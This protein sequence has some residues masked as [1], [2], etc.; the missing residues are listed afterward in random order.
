[1]HNCE[2]ESSAL[3]GQVKCEDDSCY[4]K[5]ITTVASFRS[6]DSDKDRDMLKYLKADQFAEVVIEGK[7][8]RTHED[9]VFN[10]KLSLAGRT[11]PLKPMKLQ[12]EKDWS[13]VRIR[14]DFDWSIFDF[15]IEAPK[16]LGMPIQ[17]VVRMFIDITFER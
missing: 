3:S 1:M 5:L 11:L 7:A 16:L 2:G 6:R 9:F 14:G 12:F 8:Q 4:V 15:N 17:P 10:A 13:R